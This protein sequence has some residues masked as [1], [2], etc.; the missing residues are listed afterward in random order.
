MFILHKIQKNMRIRNHRKLDG[1]CRKQKKRKKVK[2]C[3]PGT[4]SLKNVTPQDVF[5]LKMSCPLTISLLKSS[6]PTQF[7]PLTTQFHPLTRFDLRTHGGIT[8]SSSKNVQPPHVLPIIVI[9][10]KNAYYCNLP[11]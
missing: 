9:F 4:F 8:I 1:G 6:T 2:T 10:K 11:N 7:H 5:F 3:T